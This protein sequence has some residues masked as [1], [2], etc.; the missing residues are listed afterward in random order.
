MYELKNT[1]IVKS[2]KIKKFLNYTKPKF[3]NDIINIFWILNH[4][5]TD[6]LEFVKIKFKI[7]TYG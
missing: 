6:N 7:F 1:W 3:L 5:L 2:R 4:E